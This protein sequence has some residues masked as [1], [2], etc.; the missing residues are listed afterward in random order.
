MVGM[1]EDSVYYDKH[2]IIEVKLYRKKVY[3]RNLREVLAYDWQYY[4]Y[5]ILIRF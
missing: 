2:I 3:L 1:E 5:E 4:L